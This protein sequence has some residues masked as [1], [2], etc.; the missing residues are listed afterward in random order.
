VRLAAALGALAAG[1]AG[2]TVT[3][4]PRP[5]FPAPAASVPSAD[6][7]VVVSS[8]P[9]ASVTVSSS[10]G[11]PSFRGLPAVG[12]VRTANRSFLV[13]GRDGASGRILV[14]PG[15][16][17]FDFKNYVWPP[18]IP[19]GEREFVYEQVV[20]AHEAGETLYVEN[21]HST[22]ASSSYGRNAYITAIDLKTK[23]PLWRSPALVANAGTFLVDDRYVIAGYG[24]TREPDYLY[25]LDRRTGRAV[26]RLLLPSAPERITWRG[27]Q[28]HVRTYDHDVVVS[29]RED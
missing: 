24:F 14:A 11:G 29:L 27:R 19:P 12:R 20:W 8:R 4:L 21:A 22:Y 13:F 25:L 16:Y 17:A 6:R 2:V 10:L 7:L 9:N 26:E 15:R 28:I 1:S 18:R 5:A 3:V 23:K